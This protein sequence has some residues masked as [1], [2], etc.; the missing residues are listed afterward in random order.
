MAAVPGTCTHHW[1]L[2]TTARARDSESVRC[3]LIETGITVSPIG[4]INF[5]V[6]D[7]CGNT[8]GCYGTEVRAIS[9]SYECISRI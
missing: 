8:T 5:G 2:G 7:G 6:N 4:I 3:E 1:D 9:R